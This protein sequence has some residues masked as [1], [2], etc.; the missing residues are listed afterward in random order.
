ML[1]EVEIEILYGVKGTELT[2]VFRFFVFFLCFFR[3]KKYFLN[4]F[5]SS[6]LS[7]Y[8]TATQTTEKKNSFNP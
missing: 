1:S 3:C 6:I 4:L 8:N 2:E 7:K 5:L